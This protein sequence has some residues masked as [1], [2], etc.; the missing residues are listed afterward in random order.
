VDRLEQGQQT[1]CVEAYPMFSLDAGPLSELREKYG[2][3]VEAEGLLVF[4][5]R[6][7]LLQEDIPPRVLICME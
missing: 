6:L 4:H 5:L 1:I 2:S 7:I 3:L